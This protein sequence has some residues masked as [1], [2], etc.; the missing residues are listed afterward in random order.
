MVFKVTS[1]AGVKHD[2]GLHF[3][4][5][6]LTMLELFS[7]DL[8]DIDT[9]DEFKYIHE[10]LVCAYGRPTA[11]ALQKGKYSQNQWLF[12]KFEITNNQTEDSGQSVI[13]KFYGGVT[14]TPDG[15]WTR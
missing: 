4:N 13:F 12:G 9:D 14:L 2:L 15:F 7:F 5:Q 3:S 8:S 1:L 11:S 10:Q 6:Q